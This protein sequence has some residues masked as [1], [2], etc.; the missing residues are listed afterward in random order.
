MEGEFE[1]FDVDVEDNEAIV[2]LAKDEGIDLVVVGPEVPLCNGAVDAL[3]EAGIPAYGPNQSAARL[4]GSKAFSKDFFARQGIPTA[5]YGNFSEVGPALEYLSGCKM[6]IVVKA[7]DWPPAKGIDLR[8]PRGSG[9]C[10][11]GHVGR[12]EFRGKRKRG[13]NRG[14]PRRRGGIPSPDLLRRKLLP[15]L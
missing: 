9:S 5:E 11:P 2:N 4:E 3:T 1:T 14:V 10:G 8:K 7:S 12:V 15:F 13:R 6:P